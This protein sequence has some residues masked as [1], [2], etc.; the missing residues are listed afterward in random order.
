MLL[1][2]AVAWSVVYWLDF[3]QSPYGA[4]RV[5][6]LLVRNPRSDGPQSLMVGSGFGHE[7]VSWWPDGVAQP[8]R[9]RQ[10]FA[11]TW[12][13]AEAVETYS[14]S[15]FAAGWP[16]LSLAAWSEA[17]SSDSRRLRESEEPASLRHWD[18]PAP[19]KPDT[20]SPYSPRM[21]PCRPI[22]LG[23]AVNTVFYAAVLWLLLGGPFILRRWVRRRA[24]RCEKCGY[25]GGTSPT[26]TECGAALHHA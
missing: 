23:F 16:M 4:M 6:P 24:G 5:T 21:Y 20:W 12:W 8:G 1:N 19:L 9:L 14:A 10:W 18:L 11:Q 26:C 7:S 17:A 25:P 15:G 22:P 3:H 13:P 2:S